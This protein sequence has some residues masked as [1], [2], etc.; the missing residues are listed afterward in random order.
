MAQEAILNG[1]TYTDGTSDEGSGKKYLAN[2]GHIQ[3]FV[4]C[5]SDMIVEVGNAADSAA[6]SA[7]TRYKGTSTTSLTIGTGTKVFTLIETER[8]WT[9]GSEL[10]A[11]SQADTDN[12]MKG[13]VTAYSHP[14][15]TVD[16]NTV[17][18]SGTFSD[19]FIGADVTGAGAINIIDDLSPQLGANL[20]LNSF[21]IP[22]VVLDAEIV[23]KHTIFIPAGA[24]VSRTTAGAED[25][26]TE[27]TTNKVI[28][29][30]K[31]FDTAADEFVQFGVQMPKG[32][33]ASSLTAQFVWSHPSTSTPFGVRFFIQAVAFV[34]GDAADTAFGTAVGHTADIGGVT[35]DIYITPVT[36]T[37]TV[38]NT[39]A[40]SDFVIFQVYRDVSDAGDTLA[41][42]ARL[43]GVSI[44]Y[45]TDAATD[46]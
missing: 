42:D 21:D 40:K 24:M 30:T 28:L 27:T 1:T 38:G 11:S 14:T 23:G 20:D 13:V 45:T 16:V 2:G 29:S 5:L 39:P 7:S 6:E 22:G 15:L 12:H 19:W 36:G 44:F 18:G 26:K 4:P 8:S 25:G 3:N 37:V 10:K 9:V 17:G 46:D 35:D 31:N 33:N 34:D 43:H 41:V 32:W